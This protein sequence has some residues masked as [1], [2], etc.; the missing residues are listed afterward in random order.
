MVSKMNELCETG[1]QFSMDDFGTG[2]CSLIYLKKLPFNQIKIDASFVRDVTH[3]PSDAEIV[4][5]ILAMSRT[6]GF[7]TIAEGVET[8]EQHR[9]LADNGCQKFQGFLFARPMPAE[10]FSALLNRPLVPQN[11]SEARARY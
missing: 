4:R 7:D 5:T 11:K 8:P 9:F 1:V 6:L 2:Y 3:D 10:K